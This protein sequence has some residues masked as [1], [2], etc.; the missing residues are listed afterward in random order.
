MKKLQAPSS[1]L[2]R[3]ARLQAFKYCQ[4]LRVWCLW[5]GISLVLG[6]WCVELASAAPK[7]LSPIISTGADGKLACDVDARGNHVP[8]FSTCGYAG[9]DRQIPDAP[10]RIVVAPVHGDETAGIQKAIDYVASLS[11]DTNGIRGAILL[12]KGRHEIFGQLLI[13]NFGVVLRGEGAV[14]GFG[15]FLLDFFV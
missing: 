5:L 1:K 7:K 8:D 12:Q 13:T 4:P 11:A 9:G 14:G 15:G 6:A 2:Q 10:I 3:S